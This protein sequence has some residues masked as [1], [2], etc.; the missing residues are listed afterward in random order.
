MARLQQGGVREEALRGDGAERLLRELAVP[1]GVRRAILAR[2]GG[3]GGGAFSPAGPGQLGGLGSGD[4]SAFSSVG[5]G[6]GGGRGIGGA[7]SPLGGGG[8]VSMQAGGG[9]RGEVAVVV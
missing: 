9:T 5:S 8:G 7:M 1:V 4:G 3:G 6:G 2:F